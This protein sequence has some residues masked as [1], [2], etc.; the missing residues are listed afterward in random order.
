MSRRYAWL[1]LPFAVHGFIEK[2]AGPV[3]SV[4]PITGPYTSSFAAT[5]TT[6][7]GSVFVKVAEEA[8]AP[9]SA[10]A[11]TSEIAASAVTGVLSPR[12]LRHGTVDG[13]RVLVF[14]HVEGRP[15]RL[16]LDSPDMVLVVGAL[17]RIGRIRP[18]RSAG[19]PT[20]AARLREHLPPGRTGPLCGNT[21]LHTDLTSANMIV[22][23]DGR[24][25]VVDWGQVALGP[26]WAEVGYLGANLVDAGHNL[27][28]V[29]R[30]MWRFPD[31]RRASPTARRALAKAMVGHSGD[32]S[33]WWTL[34]A[35]PPIV[36]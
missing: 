23:P 20:L 24:L 2:T 5:V 34:L 11:Q 4:E 29:R 15:L 25:S 16:C 30:W 8:T 26:P 3:L 9:L 6:P 10:R 21:L 31:R 7:T 14:E 33:T 12:L 19:L 22:R 18:G 35:E 13:W 17:D 1:E 32:H 28:E 36:G 27:G